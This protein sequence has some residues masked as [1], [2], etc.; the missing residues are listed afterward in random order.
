MIVCNTVLPARDT[1]YV[2]KIHEFSLQ[3]HPNNKVVDTF[4]E[5]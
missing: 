4:F 1:E 2:E 3:V 5:M